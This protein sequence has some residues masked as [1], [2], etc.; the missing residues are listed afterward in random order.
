MKR[1]TVENEKECDKTKEEASEVIKEMSPEELEA[2]KLE[3]YRKFI[4]PLTEYH[5]D[6]LKNRK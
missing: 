1:M 3:R 6:D 2:F 5:V 4:G